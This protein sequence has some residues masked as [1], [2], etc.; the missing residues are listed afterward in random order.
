VARALPTLFVIV[1]L[2]ATAAAFVVTQDFKQQKSPITRTRVGQVVP[3]E[4]LR[5]GLPVFSPVCNCAKGRVAIRFFLRKP[6][7]LTVDIVRGDR[8]VDTLVQDK[9]YRRGWVRLTWDGIQESGIAVAD[10]TYQPRVHMQHKTI[11]LPNRIRVDTRAPKLIGVEVRPASRLLSPD[12]DGRGD[13]MTFRYRLDEPGHG[14]LFVD[15]KQQLYSRFPRVQDTI[16]FYGKVGGKPL[17]KGAH[18]LTF[19]A[20]DQAG[21]RSTPERIGTL[22]IRYVTLGRRLVSIG[23]GERFYIRVSSDAKAVGYRFAGRSGRARPGTIVLRAPKKP[24][25][26]RLYVTAGDHAAGARVKVERIR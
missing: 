18:V 26:Y 22:T 13:V 8:R 5:V 7:R 20:E 11:T 16:R 21:N 25:T 1:L 4:P 24:G 17:A 23:P 15:R 3:G 12:G 6:D 19:A 2:G 9:P 14:I 10:G